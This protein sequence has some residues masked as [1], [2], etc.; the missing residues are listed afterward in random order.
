MTSLTLERRK[1]LSWSFVDT[2][3]A[4]GQQNMAYDGE[5]LNA[6]VKGGVRRPVFRFFEWKTPTVSYGYLLDESRVKEWAWVH[7]IDEI[8][9]RPTAGG[10]VIHK[11]DLSFSLCWPRHHAILPENPRSCYQVIHSLVRQGLANY[12]GQKQPSLFVQPMC[13]DPLPFSRPRSSHPLSI[14]FESPVCNDIMIENRKIVGG[15]LRLARNAILYQG[16]IQLEGAEKKSL[17][18]QILLSFEAFAAGHK[19]PA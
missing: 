4:S 14:C 13:A 2:G 15:A 16:T 1:A 10:T 12:F 8:V 5:T 9:R 19:Q 7:R 11:M 18:K 6:M 17:K 3:A